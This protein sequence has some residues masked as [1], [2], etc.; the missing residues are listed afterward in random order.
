MLYSS[1]RLRHRTRPKSEGGEGCGCWNQLD[2]LILEE[3]ARSIGVQSL[4]DPLPG[5]GNI[6]IMIILDKD[7]A[8][9]LQPF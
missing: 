7:W 3:H 2:H 1:S 6:H 5:C 8:A 4:L 9:I